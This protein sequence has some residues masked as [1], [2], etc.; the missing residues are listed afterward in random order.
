MILVLLLF[1]NAKYNGLTGCP[2]TASIY[3]TRKDGKL[4]NLQIATDSCEVTLLGNSAVY[5]YGQET[6][7]SGTE[8]IVSRQ[9][10]LKK[11]FYQ[12]NWEE[13]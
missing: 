6:R 8:D 12:I 9:D 3:L 11:I 10:I 1:S 5:Y 4:I 7:D 2:F 13:K